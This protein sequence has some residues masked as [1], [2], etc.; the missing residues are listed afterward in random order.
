MKFSTFTIIPTSCLVIVALANPFDGCIS[1][2]N[3]RCSDC[4]E[5]KVLINQTGSGSK[6]PRTI[7]A[8]FKSSRLPRARKWTTVSPGR[9]AM[10]S[11][12]PSSIVALLEG[13]WRHL[14]KRNPQVLHYRGYLFAQDSRLCRLHMRTLLIQGCEQHDFH[15]LEDLL[16][17]SQ[18]QVRVECRFWKSFLA[19]LLQ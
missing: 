1:Q 15:M 8:S 6:R 5:T 3:R 19:Q 11:I 17:A 14:R 2:E 4:H 7:V 18:L 9:R 12:R 16:S 10:H 13:L